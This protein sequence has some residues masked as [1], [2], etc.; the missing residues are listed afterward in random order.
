MNKLLSLLCYQ[1][2]LFAVIKYSEKRISREEGFIWITVPGYIPPRQ[3]NH[4]VRSLRVHSTK[5]SRSRRGAGEMTH[6]LFV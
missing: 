1:T 4:R 2:F 3:G 5:Q 6:I